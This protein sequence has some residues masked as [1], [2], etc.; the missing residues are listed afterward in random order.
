MIRPAI[1]ST[2]IPAL[3]DG[4]TTRL[5]P[6]ARHLNAAFVFGVAVLLAVGPV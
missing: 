4:V 3:A 6:P 2:A 5:G 1:L